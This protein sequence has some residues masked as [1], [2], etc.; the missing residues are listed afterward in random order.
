MALIVKHISFDSFQLNINNNKGNVEYVTI[1]IY[2]KNLKELIICSYY[3][4]KRIVYEQLFE[5]LENK[6]NNLLII[7]EFNAKHFNL[8]SEE[9]NHYGTKL[10]D[11]LNYCNLFVVQN[12]NH[13][14][15][16]RFRDK[17]DTIDYIIIS[18]SLIANI[19]DVNSGMDITLDHCTMT[20]TLKSK[21][22]RS[23]DRNISLKLYHKADWSNLNRN[24]KNKLNN[25]LEYLTF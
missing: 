19:S 12:N 20:V 4:P 11:M 8:D 1:K 6:S 16:D 17:M 23:E 22:L 9:T 13:T 7:E 5:K 21:K 3:S 15:Y 18:P 24:I 25:Y 10:M 2:T 14:R